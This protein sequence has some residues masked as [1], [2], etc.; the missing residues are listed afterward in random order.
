MIIAVAMLL[1][2]KGFKHMHLGLTTMNN[3]FIIAMV[4]AKVD[5]HLYFRQDTSANHFHGQR[6]DEAAH[7]KR[8]ARPRRA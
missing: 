2:L 6:F 7:E 4:G 1:F 5:G 8:T 3:Y